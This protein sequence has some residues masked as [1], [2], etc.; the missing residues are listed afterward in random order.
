LEFLVLAHVGS[1]HLLDLAGFEQ[2]AQTK[3]VYAGIVADAGQVLYARIP[4][5]RNQ[6]FGNAAKAESTHRYGLA[7]SDDVLERRFSTRVNFIHH[8]HPYSS[9]M[10]W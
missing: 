7:V 1:N 6:R 2:L 4:Q 10:L 3:T 5:R 8:S 9:F